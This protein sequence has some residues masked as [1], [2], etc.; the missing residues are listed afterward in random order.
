MSLQQ[1]PNQSTEA[2]QAVASTQ[3]T[4]IT[5][6]RGTPEAVTIN[7]VAPPTI[8]A[9]ATGQPGGATVSYTEPVLQVVRG[10]NVLGSLDAKDADL[11]LPL[12]LATLRLGTLTNVTE[13]ANGTS[14]GGSAVL[15]D[16]AVGGPGTVLPSLVHLAIAPLTATATAPSGGVV[17]PPTSPSTNPLSEVHKDLS[18]TVAYP[19]TPFQY[20]VAIPNRGTCTLTNVVATDTVTGPAGSTVSGTA[21]AAAS[22]QGL[23]TTWD[24]GTVAPNQTVDLVLDVTPPGTLAAGTSYSNTVTVT[25]DCNGTPVSKT[26]S[27]S[28]PSSL[29]ATSPTGSTCSVAGSNKAASH[30]EVVPGESFD[31]YIHV[32]NSSDEPCDAVTVTDPLGSNVQFVSCT[33]GCVVSGRTVTWSLG[34]LAP[35]ESEDL[36]VTV[37]ASSTAAAGTTLPNTATI[38]PAK[39]G[40]ESVSTSGPTVGSTSVLAPPSPATP[41]STSPGQSPVVQGSSGSQP[42]TSPSGPAQTSAVP[43]TGPATEAA[44]GSAS[45]TSVHTGLW[46]AG[47][48]PY[49]VGLVTF[50]LVL[51]GWPRLQRLL[52]HDWR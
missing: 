46:F 35:G 39:G 32:L 14:A 15:L 8:V 1:V 3:L 25:G 13:A 48:T 19:S 30:L 45:P 16:V 42:A 24:V 36:S 29:G 4:A 51:L 43:P 31:Y 47:S 20:I 50:G 44:S 12:G 2:V 5:L 34:T 27:I 7:V 23:T 40:P 49:L 41:P 38:S 52:P 6:F 22:V 33:G 28:G 17:C 18:A 11:T 37:D 21:P 26:A 10:G 9:T